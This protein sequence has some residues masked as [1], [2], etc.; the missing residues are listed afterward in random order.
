MKNLPGF[1]MPIFNHAIIIVI[2]I[3][4][5]F[6]MSQT[7]DLTKRESSDFISYEKLIGG[8]LVDSIETFGIMDNPLGDQTKHIDTKTYIFNRTNDDFYPQLHVWYHFDENEETKAIRYNWGFYNPS[9]SSKGKKKDIKKL[10]RKEEIFEA[11]NDSIY[12]IIFSLFGEPLK[13]E[14]V[15]NNDQ[16]IIKES[17]WEDSE[18]IIRLHMKFNRELITVPIVGIMADFR[19][20]ILMRYK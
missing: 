14:V 3:I 6:L 7:I 20:E 9:F 17:Y 2:A 11:K 19:I 1:R 10:T 5:E 8:V 15:T 4:P 13:S 12:N 18:K 16:T